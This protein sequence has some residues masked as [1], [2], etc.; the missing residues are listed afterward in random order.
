MKTLAKDKDLWGRDC[1]GHSLR[2]GACSNLHVCD[3]RIV[4]QLYSGG[5]LGGLP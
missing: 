2:E 1:S 4:P 5:G 3:H